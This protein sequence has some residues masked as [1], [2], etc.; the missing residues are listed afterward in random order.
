MTELAEQAADAVDAGRARM[1]IAVARAVH[2]QLALLLQGLRRHEANVGPLHRFADG[3]GIG[4]VVLAANAAHAVRG[5]ELGRDQ[6]HGV[7]QCGEQAR[8][9]VCA[10]TR[11]HR[12]GARR[13]G[14][15]QLVQPGTRHR[16]PHQ[17][18]L[19]RFIHTMD[20]KLVLQTRSW[21]GRCRRRQCSHDFPSRRWLMETNTSHRGTSMPYSA[22]QRAPR[23]GEVPFIR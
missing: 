22:T 5:D 6:A 21:Q 3:C 16:G 20:C 10:G 11:F 7:A 2:H 23:D 12:H 1:D 17:R 14:R 15:N 19:T 9:V 8:P 4:R 13:Q 18:G